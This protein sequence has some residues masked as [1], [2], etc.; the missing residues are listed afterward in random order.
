MKDDKDVEKKPDNQPQCLSR[1][2]RNTV[3]PSTCAAG[4]T[5]NATVIGI[6]I[7]GCP[8][9]RAHTRKSTYS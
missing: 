3:V 6:A 4:A 9:D 5:P 2:T 1:T 7:C 8:I